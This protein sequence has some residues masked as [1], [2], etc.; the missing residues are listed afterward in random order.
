[1]KGQQRRR[2][3][4]LLVKLKVALSQLGYKINEIQWDHTPPLALREWDPVAKDTIPAANDPNHIRILLIEEHRLVT[5]GRHGES[6]LSISFN[7]DTSRAAKVKRL[8]KQQAEVR[9]R[10]LSKEPGQ[11]VPKKQSI[12]GRGFRR[13]E[14][15]PRRCSVELARMRGDHL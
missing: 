12:K 14:R 9:A 7:G 5:T 6:D 4:P 13:A 15:K 11:P 1:M 8:E 10:L 3:I 2:S